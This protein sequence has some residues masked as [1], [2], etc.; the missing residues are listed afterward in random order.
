MQLRFAGCLIDSGTREVFRGGQ[1]VPLSPKAFQLLELLAAR[2]PNAI[3]K[4][5][6]RERLLPDTFV[7]DGNL[8]NLVHEIRQGLEDNARQPRVIRTVPRVGYAFKAEVDSLS[9]AA[10]AQTRSA[11]RLFWGV[12]EIALLE[13]ENVLGRDEH[14]TVALNDVSISRHHCRI[15]IDVMGA[16]LED[17]GSKNGTRVQG[18]RIEHSVPLHDGDEIRLG[19]VMLVF[20][21]FEGS[22]V[23]RE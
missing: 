23:T 21:R 15:V 14:A 20:R 22:T 7:A 12:R 17:L 11:Y 5:E 19:S 8:A 3:S 18:R 9:T 16:R 2:R 6:I 1:Q 4:Q 13:G 10:G